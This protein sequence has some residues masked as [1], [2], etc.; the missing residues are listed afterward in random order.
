[1]RG[2][3][4]TSVVTTLLMLAA[5]ACGGGSD[6]T[7]PPDADGVVGVYTLSTING[8][9]LPQVV[10]QNGNDTAEVTQGIVT[11]KADKTFTDV[12]HLR[13]TVSG[14]VTTV[15]DS[16]VGSW[17]RQGNTVT[18]NAVGFVP[19]QM[20]WNGSDRLTQLVDILTLVYM[21]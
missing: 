17:T 2:A 8:A 13:L 20:T 5:A 9:M 3:V 14:N 18:L 6:T 15:A 12:I 1:M 19:Y 7:A 16:T 11:L 4:R 10:D 21:K